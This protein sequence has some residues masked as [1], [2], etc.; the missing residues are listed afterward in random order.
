MSDQFVT[1]TRTSWLGN[2]ANSVVGV[3]IGILMFVVAFPVLWI[4][5]GRTNMAVVAQSSVLVDGANVSG[6]TEGKQVAV[7]GVLSSDERLGDAP[8]LELGPYIQLS[9][10][11]EMY[12]WVEHKETETQ[13]ETGG[14]STTKT[15]Y[16]YSREWTSSP[17][18]SSSFE[19]PSGHENPPM[20]VE[21]K[22]VTVA[23]ARVGAY[24][25]VPA[26]I[27]LPDGQAL[28]LNDE[29][30]TSDD[31]R[32]L[33]GDYIFI[34]RGSIGAPQLG[35]TR[36]SYSA[37][38]ANSPAIA[39]GKQQGSGL[40][41]YVTPKNDRLYRL[42][43]NTDREGAIRQMDTEYRIT[44][45]LLRLLGFFLMWIG[46]CLCF[47]P[48]NAVLDVLPFLGNLGRLMVGVVMLLVALVLS[49]VTIVVSMLAHNIVALLIVLG[50]LIG[51]AMVWSRL[52]QR[53][54]PAAV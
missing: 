29:I 14:S 45:W 23:S 26:N 5:E 17:E 4:N 15:T 52:Q 18:R 25:I 12:A 20:A 32:E 38:P 47:G 8:Y 33:A 41:P 49:T 10:T 27:E 21:S 2:I 54:G 46:L 42:F 39:F 1:V 3:L 36:I 24:S 50:L 35:D 9:R 16:T 7:A 44:G 11:A 13:K 48:I 53:K 28:Q 19:H 22:K 30:V 51:G 40:A 6:S 34:G 31:R 43:L 37:V